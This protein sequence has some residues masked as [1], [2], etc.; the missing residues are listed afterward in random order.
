MPVIIYHIILVTGFMYHRNN[1]KNDNRASYII[2]Q[3][4]FT[5]QR[6]GNQELQSQAL[7][8]T[9]P[10]LQTQINNI[11]GPSGGNNPDV[12]TM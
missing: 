6:K 1:T 5:Y 12:G 11:T 9:V 8:I 3:N 7:H 4:Y 2:Q 10:D